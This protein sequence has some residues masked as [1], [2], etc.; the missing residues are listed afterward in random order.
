MLCFQVHVQGAGLVVNRH[1]PASMMS[2]SRMMPNLSAEG[3]LVHRRPSSPLE[4]MQDGSQQM[5]LLQRAFQ[6]YL[7]LYL[8][9]Q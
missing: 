9:I 2:L 7:V 8:V 6:T 3:R 5:S 4:R 1:N